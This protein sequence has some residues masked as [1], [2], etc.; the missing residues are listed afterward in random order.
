MCVCWDGGKITRRIFFN[1]RVEL[2][3]KGGEGLNN[4]GQKAN[5]PAHHTSRDSGVRGWA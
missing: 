1:S 2:D 3:C 4:G 5:V